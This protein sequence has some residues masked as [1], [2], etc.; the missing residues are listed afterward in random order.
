MAQNLIALALL[1]GAGECSFESR[2]GGAAVT[3]D[4]ARC[5]QSGGLVAHLL[6]QHQ[7][8]DGLRAREQLP[9]HTEIELVAEARA[10]T[11]C[12]LRLAVQPVRK[13]VRQLPNLGLSRWCHALVAFANLM[14]DK[15]W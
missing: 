13:G 7:P 15:S 5:M 10:M 14:G 6:S 11:H 3:S 1:L 9:A 12:L 4:I 2:D 8:D